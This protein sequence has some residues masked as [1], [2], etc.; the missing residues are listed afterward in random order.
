LLSL[1]AIAIV[2]GLL[3]QP[4]IAFFAAVTGYIL[5]GIAE[6]GFLLNRRRIERRRRR[7]LAR[8]K[9][10]TGVDDDDEAEDIETYA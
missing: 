7:R 5:L 2:G 8:G 3:V 1:A 10:R 4:A 6:G 9:G